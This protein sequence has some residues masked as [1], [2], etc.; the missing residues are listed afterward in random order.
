MRRMGYLTTFVC[1]AA[2][3]ATLTGCSPSQTSSS[4]ASSPAPSTAS[5]ESATV[6]RPWTVPDC[7]SPSQVSSTFHGRVLLNRSYP[8]R[9][10]E[11]CTYTVTVDGAAKS[12]L[13]TMQFQQFQQSPG[14]T[15][16]S[17]EDDVNNGIASSSTVTAVKN[18][19]QAAFSVTADSLGQV[20]VFVLEN[21]IEFSVIGGPAITD[22]QGMARTTL[23]D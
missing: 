14:A 13:I 19:G 4:G 17:F 18:L 2:I 1:C 8:P 10:T 16:A 6:S 20:A 23:A 22:V 12:S 21:N 3:A 11:T 9:A 5:P 15:Y 7:P